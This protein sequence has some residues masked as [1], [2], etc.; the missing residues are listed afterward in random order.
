MTDH[1]MEVDDGSVD[2]GV[3]AGEKKT[4]N[5]KKRKRKKVAVAGVEDA[6]KLKHASTLDSPISQTTTIS[7]LETELA[8]IQSEI[9]T[10]KANLEEL[11]KKLENFLAP[12]PCRRCSKNRW[13][14]ILIPGQS[15]CRLCQSS[16]NDSDCNFE[17]EVS[18]TSQSEPSP[19]EYQSYSSTIESTIS[20]PSDSSSLGASALDHIIHAFD[21]PLNT[22]DMMIEDPDLMPT[23]DDFVLAWSFC[24]ANGTQPPLWFGMDGDHFLRTFFSQ[25]PYLR[26]A[27]C[28]FAAH[29]RIPPL[30]EPVC[31]SL[32]QRARK[33]IFRMEGNEVCVEMV[34]AL[35]YLFLFSMHK[36]QPSIGRK[37]LERGAEILLELR[38]DVDPD[39]S[40]WLFPLNLTPRQKEDR[41]RAFWALYGWFIT[42]LG[43]NPDASFT[44]PL[45]DNG[46]KPP[47][48][49]VDQGQRI[50]ERSPS[51]KWSNALSK[52]VY[53]N[54]QILMNPP[55]SITTLLES[56]T[57][58]DLESSFN[59]ALLKC[60]D[61]VLYA[62]SPFNYGG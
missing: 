33:A 47:H 45:S 51:V 52:I 7:A 53:K 30:P 38:L 23:M 35:T 4:K 40:P 12:Q 54:R 55:Q 41:R 3:A 56:A 28:A 60:A 10:P 20:L 34:K 46:V 6:K 39:D 48:E 9:Y 17:L 44:V 18:T 1:G 27:L 31:F 62:E 43:L 16:G 5:K 15:A 22:T 49:V 59:D 19:T 58:Q 13:R 24:T 42:D 2:V 8:R 26:L 50:F 32:F 29:S 21:Q 36:G 25:P 37:F 61:L 57:H 14:C 11:K